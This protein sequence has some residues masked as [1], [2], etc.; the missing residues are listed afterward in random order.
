MSQ[1]SRQAPAYSSSSDDP[2]S[3]HEPK[4]PVGRTRNEHG[5]PTESRTDPL[6]WQSRPPEFIRTPLSNRGWRSPHLKH[7]TQKGTLAKRLTK[8]RDLKQTVLPIRGS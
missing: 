7:Y 5:V 6:W 8:E 1:Q 2:E 4:G 3:A